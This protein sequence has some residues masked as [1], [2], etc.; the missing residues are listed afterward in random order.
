[1][2]GEDMKTKHAFIVAH[3]SEHANGNLLLVSDSGATLGSL[4]LHLW[5]TNSA[6]SL[7]RQQEPVVPGNPGLVASLASMK[8]TSKN[9]IF[10]HRRF[11]IGLT[12]C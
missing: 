1:M 8:G 12:I 11:R 10:A 5:I 9:A 7:S 4:A 2:G 6:T 3:A